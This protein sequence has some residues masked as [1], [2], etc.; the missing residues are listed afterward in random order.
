M[1]FFMEHLSMFATLKTSQAS[2]GITA[3]TIHI[4]AFVGAWSVGFFG[5]SLF[6]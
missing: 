3:L 5:F 6:M 4:G 1:K 2:D